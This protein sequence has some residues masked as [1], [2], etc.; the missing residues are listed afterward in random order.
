MTT[1]YLI[2]ILFISNISFGQENQNN[3]ILNLND[4]QKKENMLK[5]YNDIKQ[6]VEVFYKKFENDSSTKTVGKSF[7]NYFRGIQILFTPLVYKP[8]F[9]FIGINPGAGY[10]NY[11]GNSTKYV[12]RFSPMKNTEYIGQQYR[13]AKETRKL[14]KL[15]GISQ[16][17]LKESVKTNYYFLATKN[18]ND[19]TKLLASLKDYDIEN[20]STKWIN[21][22]VEI[23]EPEFVICEGKSIF[24]KFTKSTVSENDDVYYKEIGNIKVIGYKRKFS[25]I[26]NKQKLAEL[27]KEKLTSK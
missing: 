22:L 5:K 1:K 16:N 19:L 9:M 4:S 14:F 10:F 20:K 24:E 25:N 2:I 17:D 23:V 7:K 8:K 11:E 3:R 27:L 15:A 18:T 21:T 26:V 12:K 13:L 6:E